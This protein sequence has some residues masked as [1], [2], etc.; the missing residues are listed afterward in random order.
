MKNNISFKN[1]FKLLSMAFALLVV[2]FFGKAASTGVSFSLKDILEPYQANA[3]EPG[4]GSD[5]G[6][7]GMDGCADSSGT[8]G[9][10]DADGSY[11]G[12]GT[13]GATTAAAVVVVTAAAVVVVTAA[14]VVVVAEMCVVFL[15]L[16]FSLLLHPVLN[17]YKKNSLFYFRRNPYF[18]RGVV[19]V[20]MESS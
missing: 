11:S 18:N 7:F 8:G 5:F 10:Y 12:A 19:L 13:G 20:C 4:E 14:A 9:G 1:I 2:S 16:L 15:S 6:S 17:G 3:D